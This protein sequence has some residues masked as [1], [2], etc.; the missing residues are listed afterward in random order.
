M[1]DSLI[2]TLKAGA[3]SL[4]FA[5][6]E[7]R[8]P[9]S[10]ASFEGVIRPM[11]ADANFELLRCPDDHRG[12]W[13]VE[14]STPEQAIRE[15]LRWLEQH[16]ARLSIVA[17]GHHLLHG[18][19]LFSRPVRINRA[20]LRQL[21]SLVSLAPLYMPHSLEAIQAV[22]A[23]HPELPQVACF[24]TAFHH[25]LPP[26]ERHFAI[27]H[28]WQDLGVRRYGFHGILYESIAEQLPDHMGR[29]AEGR[30]IVAN[31]GNSASVC[32]L[33]GRRSLA[34][35][36]SFSPLDGLPMATRPG[37]LDPEVVLYL[38]RQGLDAERIERDLH[39]SSGLLGL[40][41][42]SGD[43]RTL[44]AS[45]HPAARLA[46]DCFLHHTHRAIG[47]LV[48]AL[49]GLDALVF[50]GGI[51]V[52]APRIRQRLCDLGSWIGL[53]LD[54][55]ANVTG[56]GRISPKHASPSVWVIPADETRMVAAHTLR[57]AGLRSTV[58]F[59]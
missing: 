31:L 35:T 8:E 53:K 40:S 18:G 54:N 14:A 34:T 9:V 28:E 37:S 15:L 21:A 51:G 32:A 13:R 5:L 24:D 12:R 30:V 45:H 7:A 47:S 44:L 42:T 17:T 58:S 25:D 2:L 57:I 59:P 4:E 11:G 33:H 6:H 16:P 20:T 10:P 19:D 23:H 43:M 29:L 46:V 27:P 56:R 41:G 50:T 48:A 1:K 3:S 22:S 52:N 49:G 38:L 39:F 26:V 55:E 36:M